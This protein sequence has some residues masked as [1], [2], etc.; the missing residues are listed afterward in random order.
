MCTGDSKKNEVAITTRAKDYSPSKEKVDDIPP[1]LDQTSPPTSPPNGPLH[2]K[3]P[4]LDTVLLPPPKGVVQNSTFNPHARDAQN[5][6][7]VEDLAKAPSVMSALKVLQSCPAQLKAL[8][9]SIGGIDP[10]NTNLIIFEL[11]DHIPRLPPQLSFQIQVIVENKNICRI[12]ID[13]GS[14]TCAMSV[15]CWKSIGSPTLIESHNTL[16][17]F[18]GIGFKPYD[19][20]PSLPITLEGKSVNV[21]VEVF[22]APLDYNLLLGYSWINSMHIVVSTIFRVV[23][24]PHQGK[25]ITVDQLAF[26]NY[27]S[28]TSNVP[29]ISKTP[30]CYKNVRVDLLKDSNLMGTFQIPPPDIPPPFFASINMISNIVI[31]T[32][33]SYDPWVVPNPS[34]C[35]CYG[36]KMP[37]SSVESSY[38]D[39]QSATPSSPSLCDSSPDMLHVIFPTNEVI[40]SFMSMEDTLWD[41]GHHHSILFLE[42][43]TIET[44]QRIS[45]PSTV[46]FISSIPESQHDVM[47]EGNLSKI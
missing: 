42:C 47:Y 38:Q 16:K 21:E 33:N 5:Y 45:T 37:L 14:L 18:N 7:I 19:V 41:D 43:D 36:N 23:N 34:D 13:E 31:E 24:F 6:N 2:I 32:P 39:I 20:L 44:Y 46:I 22:D 1:S 28:R 35:L 12:V 9:K 3:R 4:G 29:F 27:D 8:L 17:A 25:V 11:E 40:M 15:T 30:P 10:T 26:F